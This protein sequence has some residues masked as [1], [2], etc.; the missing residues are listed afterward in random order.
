MRRLAVALGVVLLV[1]GLARAGRG[2][3]PVDARLRAA[4]AEAGVRPP[5]RPD[6]RDAALVALGRRL[7]FDPVLSGNRDVSCAT[8]HSPSAATVDGLALERALPRGARGRAGPRNTLALFNVGLEDRLYWD[9]RVARDPV[10]GALTTPALAIPAPVMAALDGPVAA[11]AL[12][13]PLSLVEMRGAPGTNEVASAHDDAAAWAALAARVVAAPGYRPLLRAAFPHLGVEAVTFGHLARA[14]AAFESE[15]FVALDTPFDHY[16]AGDDDAPLFFGK[17]GCA[18]CH[19]GPL[20]SDFRLHALAVPQVGPGK[21]PGEDRG[22]G[23][24]TTWPQDDYAFRTPPLRNV[25]LTAPYMHDG[26]FATLESCVRHHLDPRASYE[27]YTGAELPPELRGAI[28][29]D[30]VRSKRRLAALGPLLDPPH[31]LEADEVT[32]LVRFLRALTDPGWA[33]R[34]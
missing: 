16:L 2:H 27:S 34:G 21:T 18:S 15:T 1:A 4:L 31:H 24:I 5:R 19:C 20:L 26:C 12:F 33:A 30:P 8:C 32:S 22:L 23:A 25:A 17:A 10:T 11:Q 6:G 9:G 29:R 14:L 7:F 13:P 3:A 28:D